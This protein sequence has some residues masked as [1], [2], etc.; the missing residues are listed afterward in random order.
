MSTADE[1]TSGVRTR[2]EKTNDNDLTLTISEL[3]RYITV[4]DGAREK[5]N[6]FINNCKSAN[7][8]ANINQRPA[9][10]RYIISRLDGRAEAACSIK[11]FENWE[12]LSDFLKTH[13]GEKKH[14]THLLADLQRCRQGPSETVG[15]FALRIETQLGQ[16]LTEVTL[17]VTRK[18]D[19]SG[20][21][22]GME[23]LALHTFF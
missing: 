14:I 22:G 7:N 3:Q 15:T 17:F 11:E 2:Q 4:F 20:R 18:A 23:E 16:L 10:L 9:I 13:F 8:L 21:I 19:L 12:Q 5:L 1:K 6:S